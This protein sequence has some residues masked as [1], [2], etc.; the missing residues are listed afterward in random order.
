MCIPDGIQPH[1]EGRTSNRTG[2]TA[3]I[4]GQENLPAGCPSRELRPVPLGGKPLEVSEVQR[5]PRNLQRTETDLGIGEKQRTDGWRG[6]TEAQSALL[7]TLA[8][9]QAA[10]AAGLEKVYTQQTAQTA[11]VDK[12]QNSVDHLIQVV[13]Q[14]RPRGRSASPPPNLCYQCGKRGHFRR[15]CPDSPSVKS[16]A[17]MVDEDEE[18][19]CNGPD[20]EATPWPEQSQAD[21]Q[22]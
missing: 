6:V 18:S 12:L 4:G 16:V 8:S 14:L 17:F 19:N 20:E 15:D 10:Q 7:G 21:L 1:K 5:P 9:Q 2:S 11:R 22:N 13:S 3:T